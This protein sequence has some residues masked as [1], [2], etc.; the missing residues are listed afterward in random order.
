MLPE[1]G[2]GTPEC[3]PLSLHK[4]ITQPPFP[5]RDSLEAPLVTLVPLRECHFLDTTVAE[6]FLVVVLLLTF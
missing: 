6:L 4:L 2:L 1:I 3:A 5:A